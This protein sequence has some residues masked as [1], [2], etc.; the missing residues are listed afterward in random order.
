[1]L[2][3]ILSDCISPVVVQATLD[4]GEVVLTAATLS[5][6]EFGAQPPTPERGAMVRVGR[7]YLR[8]Y[9]RYAMFPGLAVLVT[10]M[11][12]NLLGDAVRDVLDP[13]LRRGL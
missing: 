9:W 11:G 4:L 1:M 12:S 6:I 3:H 7:N 13:R 5:F 8:N 2:C 10:V